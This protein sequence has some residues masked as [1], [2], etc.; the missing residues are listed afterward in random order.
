[1]LLQN[2][3]RL[4]NKSTTLLTISFF[5]TGKLKDKLKEWRCLPV[6]QQTWPQFKRMMT[7]SQCNLQCQSAATMGYNTANNLEQGKYSF[8]TNNFLMVTAEALEGLVECTQSD[9]TAVEN[10]TTVNNSFTNQVKDIA[11]L[12]SMMK[13]LT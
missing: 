11:E 8:E 2:C 4:C 6:M 10:L 7:R 13:N 5:K 3:C 12:K 9:S 1:M